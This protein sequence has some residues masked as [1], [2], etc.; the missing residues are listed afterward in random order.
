MLTGAMEFTITQYEQPN[1]QFPRNT[2]ET[3]PYAPVNKNQGDFS[4]GSEGESGDFAFEDIAAG[5]PDFEDNGPITPQTIDDLAG[6]FDA[7]VL[8]FS[9]VACPVCFGTGFIGGF[10]PFNSQRTVLTV[11]DV[12]LSQ[13]AEINTVKRPWTARANSFSVIIKFP[14]GALSVDVFK[15]WNSAKPAAATFKIDG[16][17]I[18]SVT[19]V[20]R[21]C[22]GGPHVLYAELNGEFTHLEIQFGLSTESVYFEFPKRSKSSDTSLLEQMEP[23]Q[24]LM[25]PNLPT[26]DSR[27]LIVES[28]QGKV[29]VVQSVDPWQS[30]QRSILG[31]SVQVR[32]IQPQ[33]LFRILP[34]KGRVM[35]KDRTTLMTRDN[36]T[37]SYRT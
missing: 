6:D 15:V 22:D 17:P 14:R 34:A 4:I 28:Q 18:N 16:I 37:G 27:D 7:S 25:S 26:V 20:L 21:A 19:D 8:G 24:I 5:I 3:S 11:A 33:E 10:T 32:V 12:Q 13:E 9:D 31:W 36:I 2:T 29:L 30:R 1:R 23:F 35:S